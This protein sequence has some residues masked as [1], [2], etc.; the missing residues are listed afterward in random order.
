M[1]TEYDNMMFMLRAGFKLYLDRML[2]NLDDEEIRENCIDK[3]C[4]LVDKYVSTKI[5]LE[6]IGTK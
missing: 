1:R 4:D 3:I 5:D 2:D 6:R